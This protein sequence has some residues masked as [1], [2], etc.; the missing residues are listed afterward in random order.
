MDT[1]S[2]IIEIIGENFHDMMLENKEFFGLKYYPKGSKYYCDGNKN[3][4]GKMKDECAGI[5][6]K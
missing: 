2:F 3:V 5:K 4:P 6:I 1:D